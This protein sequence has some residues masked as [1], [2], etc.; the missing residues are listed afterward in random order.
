MS[1]LQLLRI[2]H[3][4]DLIIYALQTS[5]VMLPELPQLH[6]IDIDVCPVCRGD[7]R[8]SVNLLTETY[9]RDCACQA[10]TPIVPGISDVM[11][12]PPETPTPEPPPEE[13]NHGPEPT[14]AFG[15]G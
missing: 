14:E 6:E 2:E 7:I 4:L 12:P 5:G 13:Q 3:R 10:P 1:S 8:F 9:I 11:V 15:K